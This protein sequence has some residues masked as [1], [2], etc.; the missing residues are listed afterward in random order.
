MSVTTAGLAPAPTSALLDDVRLAVLNAGWTFADGVLAVDGAAEIRLSVPLGDAVG[1]WHPTRE[2]PRALVAD[3]EGWARVTLVNGAAA[4]CVYD[5]TGRTLL[6]FAALD[7]AP[8]VWMRFGVSEENKTFV[9]HLTV[10]GPYRIAFEPTAASVAAAMRGLRGVLGSVKVRDG[11]REPVY[12][13]WYAFNQDVTAEGVEAEAA[14]AVEAGCG[15]LI[16]D[17]GWQEFGSGR[18]YAGVGDWVPDLTKFPDFAGHVARVQALGLRYLAW[19]APLLLG[20]SA[21]CFDEISAY[22]EEDSFVPGARVLDPRIPEVRRHVVAM[23]ARLMNDYGLDGLKIDFL[24]Q[25]M[26]YAGRPSPLA[27]ISDV[28]EAMR[29]LLAEIRAALGEEALI[30][31]RQPYTGAGLSEFGDLMRADDCPSDV[32]ANRVRTID[33]ALLATGGAVHGDMLMWDPAGPVHSAAR[34]IIGSF[35]AVPQI[36]AKLGD[37]PAEQRDMVR[38][39][40]ARWRELSHVLLDGETEPGR[41]DELYP[42]VTATLGDESVITVTADRVVRVTAGRRVTVING[43]GGAGLVLDLARECSVVRVFDAAGSRIEPT[44]GKMGPGLCTLSVPPSGMALLE[45]VQ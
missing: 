1:F 41:P 15:A 17:D 14:L 45:V 36:S 39:W 34:Q 31:L 27:D 6:A 33:V 16:L 24:E 18:G 3:W 2:W 35:H 30:E 26:V 40:L 12:S 19:V 13:T 8:E 20:S 22:A 43:T 23:C 21:H 44:A 37:L 42:V 38:F 10:P 7:P 5:S 29:V 11:A 25:V 4:G 32:T 28:G 9:V